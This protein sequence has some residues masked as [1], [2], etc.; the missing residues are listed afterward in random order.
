[1]NNADHWTVWDRALA[2]PDAATSSTGLDVGSPG[3]AAG[4]GR[5][6][7]ASCAG[8]GRRPDGQASIQAPSRRVS[9]CRS[10]VRRLSAAHRVCSQASF[11]LVPR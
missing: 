2:R 5:G 11:L 1:M 8:A 9:P 7:K 6:Q 10:R 4:P 3:P